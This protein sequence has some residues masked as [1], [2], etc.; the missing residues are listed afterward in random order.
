MTKTR[1]ERISEILEMGILTAKSEKR[2]IAD[3]DK[4]ISEEVQKEREKTWDLLIEI[5][6]Y[7]ESEHGKAARFGVQRHAEKYGYGT[8]NTDREDSDNG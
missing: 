8:Y 1:K 6:V 3:L 5:G 4:L 7:L 2:V